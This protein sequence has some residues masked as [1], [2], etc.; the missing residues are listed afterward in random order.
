MQLSHEQVVGET[1]FEVGGLQNWGHEEDVQPDV[2]VRAM[3]PVLRLE[4][5]FRFDDAAWLPPLRGAM[6]RSVLGLE[7][8]RMEERG[9]WPV[10]A[11]G[12]LGLNPQS[13]WRWVYKT[14]ATQSLVRPSFGTPPHPVVI[15][16][17]PESDWQIVPPGSTIRFQISV[18]GRMTHAFR[19]LIEAFQRAGAKGLGKAITREGMR[20]RASMIAVHQVW[21]S[22]GEESRPLWTADRGWLSEQVEPDWPEPPMAHLVRIHF[23]TPLRLEEN[24]RLVK[25]E[26]FRPAHLFAALSRRIS[27]LMSGETGT[28]LNHDFRHLKFI[29]EQLEFESAKIEWVDLER[30]STSQQTEVP[31]GGIV[32]SAVIHLTGL[33]PLF[34]WLWL[35]QWTHV[36]KGTLMGLGSIR[37]ESL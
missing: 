31:A 17:P 30:W 11:G 7:L 24:K 22:Q 2:A 18:F 35:A 32:G 6:W 13:M 20:G 25:A 1:G 19:P 5:D 23:V 4:L 12:M 29:W 34:D 8:K 10:P 26:H 33:Q 27:G 16:S 15:D 3:L 37:L 14:D 36:G 9:H 21:R 28:V